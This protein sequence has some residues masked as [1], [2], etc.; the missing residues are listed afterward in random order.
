MSVRIKD[1]AKLAGVSTATVSR[2]INNDPV[3]AEDTRL[4]VMQAIEELNYFPHQWGRNLRRQE[5]K[6]ILV[7]IPDIRNS[8]Y[9]NIL[10]GMDRMASQHKY[11]LVLSSTY[12]DPA[13]EKN[14][15]NLLKQK[16][17]DGII[18]LASTLQETE[19]AG[20][21]ERFPVVLCCEFPRDTEITHVSI[22][23]Y[24]A[25]Y[26]AVQYL[27]EQG[28]RRIAFLSSNND[29]LSTHL[30]E[31]GYWQA[32]KDNGLEADEVLLVR[33]SYSFESGLIGTNIVMNNL[34][35]PT[36]I[37]SICDV[38]ASG[39]IQALYRLNLKV[40]T[41]VAV[42]GFDDIDMAKQL[43]PPLTTIAQPL[44]LLGGISVK[45]LISK[46]LQEETKT[47]I[48]LNHELVVR[49]SA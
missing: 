38:V 33:G 45:T 22:D 32:L 46:L 12:S 24:Q 13:R 6:T 15:I 23:N 36:A 8:F 10:Y 26:D 30:R 31:A 11:N 39:A 41:D 28:H 21:A 14:L 35:P 19:L 34:H 4:K 49:G 16:Y 42:F 7:L 1:V 25:A 43:T 40:P 18:F 20:L 17:A 3:V 9:A 48:V 2:V 47:E 44:E 27:I 29:F 5:S 37:F